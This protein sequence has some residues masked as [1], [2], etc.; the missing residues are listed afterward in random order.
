MIIFIIY[1]LPLLKN[2]VIMYAF[3]RKASVVTIIHIYK[4]LG[5][6][7]KYLTISLI[8]FS[9]FISTVSAQV[10]INLS[11]TIINQAK[12]K[13]KNMVVGLKGHSFKDTSNKDGEFEVIGEITPIVNY[14]E[15]NRPKIRCNGANF[16]LIV[17]EGRQ[18]ISLDIYNVKG[19]K[20]ASI[21]RNK[22]FSEGQHSIPV[23]QNLNNVSSSVLVAVVKRGSDMS[24]F[25]IVK[26]GD[27]SYIVRDFNSY[28][29]ASQSYQT[30]RLPVALDSLTFTRYLTIEGKAKVLREFSFPVTKW[31]DEFEVTLDLIPYEAIEYG[32]TQEGRSNETVGR[33]F[34][35]PGSGTY[36]YEFQTYYNGAWCSE[37]Y[38]Y[39]MRVGGCPLGNDGGSST[40]PN[41]LVMS[42]SRLITW[43]TNNAKYIK[44]SQI[45]SLN[46]VPNPGDFIQMNEHTAMVRY[47]ASDGDVVCLD[48]NWGDK[49][50]LPRRG[51]YKNFSG[52]NGYGCRSGIT[53]NSYKSISE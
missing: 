35:K 42:W 16:K 40:R 17:P 32:M 8:L 26:I 29:L 25:R 46:F 31:V 12:F 5:G 22:I 34:G 30:S 20:V 19:V 53:G 50:V 44:R 2:I 27:N 45:S 15:L 41:W 24:K 28:A 33:E 36:P 18:T 4:L 38:S 11:G 23:F 13:V 7:M 21:L 47:I 37:F 14:F 6:P 43:F 52:L 10:K 51:N 1:R 48:G 3:N 39:C 9:F 49:V